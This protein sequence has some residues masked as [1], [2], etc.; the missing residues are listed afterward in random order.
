VKKRETVNSALLIRLLSASLFIGIL[1]SGSGDDRTK[2]EILL[3][4]KGNVPCS[5]TMSFEASGS[6]GGVSVDG[7]PSG[8]T[9]PL[10]SGFGSTVVES[11]RINVGGKEQTVTPRLAL[12]AGKRCRITVAND[13]STAVTTGD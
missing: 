10:V 4:N 11:V 7:I 2:W 9:V 12:P 1:L 8:H 6:R 5:V 13:G 3:V